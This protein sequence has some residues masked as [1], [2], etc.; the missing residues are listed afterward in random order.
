MYLRLILY[1]YTYSI[2]SYSNKW[3]VDN[4]IHDGL[5]IDIKRL[6]L[7]KLLYKHHRLVQ[8]RI[9]FGLLIKYLSGTIL[10]LYIKNQ[11]NVILFKSIPTSFKYLYH[12]AGSCWRH[13]YVASSQFI[14]DIMNWNLKN[15]KNVYK[16]FNYY[17]F[18]KCNHPSP[19]QNLLVLCVSK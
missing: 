9:T 8:L 10:Y 13:M 2:H 15:I 11:I 7:R 16:F 5:K 6:C 19:D 17:I 1:R 4:V 18:N 3:T 12:L 14:L